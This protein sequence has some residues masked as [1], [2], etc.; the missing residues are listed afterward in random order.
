MKT[1]QADIT[2]KDHKEVNNDNNSSNHPL[3]K[4]KRTE[5]TRYLRGL[6]PAHHRKSNLSAIQNDH[7]STD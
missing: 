3:M 5:A 1:E 6:V 4:Q 7:H 2:K